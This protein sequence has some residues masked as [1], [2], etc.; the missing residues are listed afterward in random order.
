MPFPSPGDLPNPEMEAGSLA[1]QAVSL[2][3]EPLR[4]FPDQGSNLGSLGR[5]VPNLFHLLEKGSVPQTSL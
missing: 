3:S 1:L 5:E 2:A 4:K